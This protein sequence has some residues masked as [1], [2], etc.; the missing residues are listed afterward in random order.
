[1]V[2]ELVLGT[3]EVKGVLDIALLL[4]VRNTDRK[5]VSQVAGVIAKNA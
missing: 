5:F 1:M 4:E 2:T 3:L